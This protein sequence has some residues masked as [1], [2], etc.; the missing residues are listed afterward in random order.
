L[1]DAVHGVRRSNVFDASGGRLGREEEFRGAD[2]AAYTLAWA[3]RCPAEVEPFGSAATTA[4]HSLVTYARFAS[5]TDTAAA[6]VYAEYSSLMAEHYYEFRGPS[7]EEERA[8]ARAHLDES[9]ID[10]DLAAYAALPM[11]YSAIFADGNLAR[12]FNLPLWPEAQSSAVSNCWQS[13]RRA[14]LELDMGFDVWVDCYEDRLAGKPLD[15]E[16]ETQ[17]AQVPEEIWNQEPT[18]VN[19]YIKQ[20]SAGSALKPLNR[21]RALFLGHGDAGKTSLIAALHGETVV[22]G[23]K[24]MTPGVAITDSEPDVLWRERPGDGALP[25]VYFWD[26]GGQVMAHQTHQFFL[27]SNCVY[28]IVLDGRR[29]AEATEAARYWLEHVRAFGDGSSVLIVGNKIDLAP[30][31]VD[32]APLTRTS[33]VSSATFRSPAQRPRARGRRSSPP[34]VPPSRTGWSM[35]CAHSQC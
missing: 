17:R 21:V 19:A 30:V 25:T 13:A 1:Y 10:H 15:I 18:L 3:A 5:D 24:T 9:L 4:F 27:R 31:W 11:D 35:P 28:V 26:F 33:Q 22:E 23:D 20:L 2:D 14:L 12:S 6:R 29:N 16:L 32:I 34:S 7:S 8:N